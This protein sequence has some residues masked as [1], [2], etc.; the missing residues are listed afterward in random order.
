MICVYI[1]ENI[2]LE[3]INEKMVN[4]LQKNWL[5]ILQFSII[6]DYILL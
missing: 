3:T 1:E 4:I 2:C 5:F 6:W